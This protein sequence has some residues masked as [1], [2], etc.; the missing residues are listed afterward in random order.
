MG[1]E[2]PGDSQP[3][4]N[5]WGSA[6]A[7]PGQMRVVPSVAEPGCGQATHTQLIGRLSERNNVKFNIKSYPFYESRT[8]PNS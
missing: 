2:E 7:S 5:A 1:R 6:W 4:M 3:I 8:F